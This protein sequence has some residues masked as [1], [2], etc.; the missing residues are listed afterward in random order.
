M[1]VWILAG[2]PE[3]PAESRP[4]TEADSQQAGAAVSGQAGGPCS[5]HRGAR[6]AVQPELR[7]TPAMKT[8][9]QHAFMGHQQNL[10]HMIAF[11]HPRKSSFLAIA[12][13][14]C[15]TRAL[16]AQVPEQACKRIARSACFMASHRHINLIQ[17]R[18]WA[19]AGHHPS[20]QPAQWEVAISQRSGAGPDSVHPQPAGTACGAPLQR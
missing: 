20:S 4:R 5:C 1:P 11:T 14:T 17:P 16:V 13:T 3:E 15:C 6:L 18:C 9:V 8:S 10:A 12:L 19:R 2:D 7:G